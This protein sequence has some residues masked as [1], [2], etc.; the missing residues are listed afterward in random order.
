MAVGVQ[1]YKILMDVKVVIDSLLE[2]ILYSDSVKV[3][4]G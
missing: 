4:Q 2:T 1:M 3:R